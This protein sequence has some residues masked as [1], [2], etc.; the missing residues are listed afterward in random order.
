MLSLVKEFFG[1][2]GRYG[3]GREMRLLAEMAGFVLLLVGGGIV[4]PITT[5]GLP[6]AVGGGI[7]FAFAAAFAFIFMRC[8]NATYCKWQTA[9]L[10]YQQSD[11]PPTKLYSGYDYVI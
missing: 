1:A 2:V 3:L 6:A 4:L 5:S 9:T 8:A 11:E 10:E 7:A